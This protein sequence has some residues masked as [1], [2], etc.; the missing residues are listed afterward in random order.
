ME[1]VELETEMAVTETVTVTA[2]V[3]MSILPTAMG[4]IIILNT[5]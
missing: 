3:I 1:T 2:A 4:I 5:Q